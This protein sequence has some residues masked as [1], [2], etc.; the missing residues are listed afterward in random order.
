MNSST[1]DFWF[2]FIPNNLTHVVSVNCNENGELPMQLECTNFELSK[3]KRAEEAKKRTAFD[4]D[5]QMRSRKQLFWSL[6]TITFFLTMI[7]L[8]VRWLCF[9]SRC[10]RANDFIF[11]WSSKL[12]HQECFQWRKETLQMKKRRKMRIIAGGRLGLAFCNCPK[13][14]LLL[15]TNEFMIKWIEWKAG[16]RIAGKYLFGKYNLLKRFLL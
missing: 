10:N 3:M 16:A 8:R 1:K 7:I 2:C 13:P 5:P 4:S 9:T 15:Q 11:G 12:Q 14:N 6:V